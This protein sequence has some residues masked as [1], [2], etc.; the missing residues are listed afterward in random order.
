MVKRICQKTGLKLSIL[1][2]GCWAFGGNEND[3][4]GE[5]SQKDVDCIVKEAFD[6]GI[7]YFDTAEAY[8]NC[9]SETSLGKAIKGIDREKIVIGSKILPSNLYADKIARHCEAS[10]KRLDTDYLDLYMIHWPVNR[11]S[12]ASF[13]KDQYV[14]DNPPSLEPAVAALQQLR[15]RG[16]IKHIGISNFGPINLAE[17]L[18]LEPAIGAN[19]LIYNLFSRAIEHDVVPACEKNGIGIIAYMPLQQAML[20]GR[21]NNISELPELRRRTRHFHRDSTPLSRHGGEGAED[22]INAALKDIKRICAELDISVPELALKWCTMNPAI[23][24]TIV[25]TRKVA[26]L[27]NSVQALDINLSPEVRD[28][29]D[30]LTRPVLETLG[31]GIDYFQGLGAQRGH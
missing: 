25:G 9:R 4:W 17:I 29:L 26:Q 24:S 8:N 2:L 28:E 16:L 7:T 15:E 14:I 22:Q 6:L 23:T 21:Y 20:T 30:K 11:H 3:Y 31:Y 18:T 13:T 19:Q 12:L 5:Q 27:R 1:G 10:L